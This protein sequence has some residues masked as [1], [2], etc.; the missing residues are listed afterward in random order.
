MTVEDHEANVAAA[1]KALD[2]A[3]AKAA[4]KEF[5]KWVEP[6]PS[7]I[8][9][10]N[11]NMTAPAFPEYHV[12]RTGKLTVLVRDADEEARALTVKEGV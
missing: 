3:K 2:E 6:D 5:P 7:H 11:G 10:T 1:Q 4:F 9:R 12:D 8:D